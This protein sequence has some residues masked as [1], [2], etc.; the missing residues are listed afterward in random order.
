MGEKSIVSALAW[1]TSVKVVAVFSSILRDEEQYDAVR[2]V[3]DLITDALK[4]FAEQIK[5]ERHRLTGLPTSNKQA[6]STSEGAPEE[7]GTQ[8]THPVED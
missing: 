7:A 3:N 8:S 6:P 5:R 1:A 4:Q 2:E